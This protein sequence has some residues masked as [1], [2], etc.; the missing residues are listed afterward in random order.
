VDGIDTAG[1]AKAKITK[2]AES[3][4]MSALRMMISFCNA[5]HLNNPAE[6]QVPAYAKGM[7]KS[8][9]LTAASRRKRYHTRA[10]S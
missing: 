2:P 1:L 8:I 10:R 6:T 7:L 4:T 5:L 9:Y 3:A